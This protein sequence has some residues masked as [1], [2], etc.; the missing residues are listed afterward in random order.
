MSGSASTSP[1]SKDDIQANVVAVLQEMTADWDLEFS[2]PM[3]PQTRLIEDLAFESID[4]VQFIVALEQRFNRKGLPFEQ[5]FMRD[6][7]YV[8]EMQVSEI[9]DFL[10][11]KLS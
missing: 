3:G 1:K 2:D 11:E 8:E 5:L 9:V 6:G 7:D 10:A 4:I